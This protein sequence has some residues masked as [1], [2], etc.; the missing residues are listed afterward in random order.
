MNKGKHWHTAMHAN[1]TKAKTSATHLALPNTKL[2]LKTKAKTKTKTRTKT[3]IKT[4]IDTTKTK[5]QGGL[6]VCAREE[7][8]PRQISAFHYIFQFFH[9]SQF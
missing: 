1:W 7:N 6:S 2:K 9:I 3:G 4:K 8:H 5:T